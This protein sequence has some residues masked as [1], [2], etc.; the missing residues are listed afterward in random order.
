MAALGQAWLADHFKIL[1]PQLH[2]RFEVG[3]RPGT[4]VESGLPIE[5]LSGNAARPDDPF[6]HLEFAM[7]YE[8]LSLSLLSGVFNRIEHESPGHLARSIAARPSGI[9][10]RRCGLLFELL[11]SRTLDVQASGPYADVLD[12]K[13][14]IVDTGPRRRSA[15]WRLNDNLPGSARFCPVIARTPA[16]DAALRRDW[17]S[18]IRAIADRF[19]PSLFAR[20]AQFLY[21]K[22]TRSSFEIESESSDNSRGERFLASLKE[23]GREDINFALAE[24]RLVDVQRGIVDPRFAA[25]GFRTI[26]NYVGEAVRPGLERVHYVCPPPEIV[27]SLM[28]GL[29]DSYVRL[30]GLPPI[31]A[32]AA[33]SFGFV[34]VHPFEDGNGRIHRF[35]IHDILA[36]GG[37][38]PPGIIVPVSARMLADPRAY[39]SAL[40]HFSKTVS[41]SARYRLDGDSRLTLLNPEEIEPLYRYPSLSAHAEY[42][43]DVLDKSIREDLQQELLFLA[44][45]DSAKPAIQD[46]VDLPPRQMDLLIRLI[47]QNGGT[48]SKNKR[49]IFASLTNSEIAEIEGVV[50]G[51]FAA[52]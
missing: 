25:T 28:S 21:L 46:I 29:Q 3:S 22:E 45:Y 18:D 8:V 5:I 52:H 31:M 33:I 43:A 12:S 4:R 37:W 23:V 2:K 17:P 11:G 36:R 1:S 35:L 40:E 30:S 34:F 16:I 13:I 26:Q 44:A 48:L 39:D 20:A 50:R 19:S 10:A 51:A 24:R 7:R 6:S 15:K 14:H 32:A 27:Y 9:F 42:L 49:D 47:R 38:S 41:T